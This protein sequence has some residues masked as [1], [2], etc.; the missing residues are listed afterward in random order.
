MPE[1]RRYGSRDDVI[2]KDGDYGFVGFNNRLRPDQLTKGT[3]ADAQSV[4]LDRNGEAQVRKGIEL[5]EAPFAVGGEVLRLPTSEEIGTDVTLLPTTIRRAELLADVMELFLDPLTEQGHE[6]AVGENITVEGLAFTSPDPDPNGTFVVTDVVDGT[7]NQKVKFDL[8]GT[9][10]VT[11]SGPVVLPINLAFNLTPARGSAIAGYNMI[12]D[13]GQVTEV[14]A[15]TSF[16]DPNSNSSESII[17]AS[18]VKAVAKDLESNVVTDIYYPLGETVPPLSDMIQAFNKVFIFRDG[19]TALE[20]D[21]IYTSLAVTDL[22]VDGTYSIT[23]LGSTTQIEWNTIAGTTAVT[24]AV[25]DPITVDAVGAGTGTARSAFTLVKSGTYTQ[26]VQIDCLPGQFAITNSI[27]T[28]AGLHDVKVGDDISVMSASISGVTGADSGL[29][30]GQDYVVNKVFT[31]GSAITDITLAVNNGLEGPG[32]FEGLYKYTLTTAIA[33]NLVNGEPIIMDS[34][35]DAP[36]STGT[37]FNGSFFVQGVPSSTTFIIYTDFDVTID[38]AIYA[39]AR[40]GIDSGFQFVLDSRTVTTHVNDGNSLLTDPIFTKRVSVGLGFTH[41][42]APPY[43]TYHQRRLVMPFRYSVDAIKGQYTYR[44]I[45]DEVIISDIIDSD[46]YDEIYSQYR[47]NAGTAD[48]TVGLHS[49]SD[50]SLLV[51]NRNSIHT[52]QNTVNLQGSVA[53]LLTNEVGCVARKSIIQVG[54]QV[55][56]LS[57]NGVY[58]TQF[59]DEYNLRGT[60]TPMSEAINETINRINRNHWEES[61]AVYFDNRYYIAV[62]L[63]CTVNG[64]LVEAQRNNAIL[65]FNFLNAQWESID[66]VADETGGVNKEW[67]I[68]NLIVAGNGSARGVYAINQLGGI[69]K[70]DTRLDGRDRVVT[71]IGQ[72]ATTHSVPAS[73]TTRQYTLGAMDRKNWKQFEMHVESSSTNTS[74]FDI[75]AETENPDS[76]IPLQSLSDYISGDSLPAGEDVSIR[77]R[78]GNRRGYGI[79]YTINNT[80][81]RPKIRA[82]ETNGSISFRSTQSAE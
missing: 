12:F 48:Y 14:Y 18:N 68:E 3:L 64:V 50:N 69:H 17:I 25:N 82:I 37:D 5:I 4:R 46:T 58:G 20:W 36:P 19:N 22:V 28:V 77:A 73:I 10:P 7:V 53:K 30:I 80:Q 55:I 78:I 13:I 43:A 26:P 8:T 49:F 2:A 33:H 21:G 52:V 76:D 44:K 31:L 61:R 65:I 38:A 27:A 79:Q 74:N 81:G 9:G 71:S 39:D 70:L 56:F 72:P 47:F 59:L 41:M 29:T 62:P 23:D 63:D 45:L 60:E 57:D 32:D 24:Y 16:S 66:M 54:N 1:Y 6:F 67:D 40:V 11:Y 75:S 42:P 34:W 35:V 15:S 51:F